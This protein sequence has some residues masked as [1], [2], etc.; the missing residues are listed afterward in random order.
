MVLL[1][2][3][4]KQTQK[5]ESFLVAVVEDVIGS[6]YHGREYVTAPGMPSMDIAC[7]LSVI[8][9]HTRWRDTVVGNN[10]TFASLP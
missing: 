5:T 7:L 9:V 6:V 1:W 8:R 2:I 3:R 4:Y 10:S